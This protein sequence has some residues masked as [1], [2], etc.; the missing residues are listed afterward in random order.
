[1]TS[2]FGHAMAFSSGKR[3]RSPR[4][5][6]AQLIH[7]PLRFSPSYLMHAKDVREN[8]NSDPFAP[9]DLCVPSHHLVPCTM[10]RLD[11][12]V[13]S[14]EIKDCI[15]KLKSKENIKATFFAHH[16]FEKAKN[17]QIQT[18]GTFTNFMIGVP[19]LRP[20]IT[21]DQNLFQSMHKLLK[22]I[23]QDNVTKYMNIGWAMNG[24]REFYNPER[25]NSYEEFLP[26]QKAHITEQAAKREEKIRL[27]KHKLSDYFESGILNEKSACMA[28][29]KD[30]PLNSSERKR[31]IQFSLN[32]GLITK[33]DLPLSDQ[34]SFKLHY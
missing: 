13:S 19:S 26:L 5:Y 34:N 1:M 7:K 21:V 30:D 29:D 14:V 32:E 24:Y 12:S 8:Y 18:H 6:Q 9:I 28:L 17:G 10:I 16:H 23:N 4:E 22:D 33:H 25:Y 2:S 31:F 3:I 27:Q 11:K 20:A 15:E